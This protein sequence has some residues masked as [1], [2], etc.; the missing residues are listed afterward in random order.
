MSHFVVYPKFQRLTHENKT[1]APQQMETGE[2]GPSMP[3]HDSGNGQHVLDPGT[4]EHA[5]GQPAGTNTTAAP[6]P[7]QYHNLQF[8]SM[9]PGVPVFNPFESLTH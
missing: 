4:G 8:G 2:T 7:L 5:L 6:N 1:H 9:Y 3:Q